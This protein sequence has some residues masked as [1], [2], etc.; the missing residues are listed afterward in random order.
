MAAPAQRGQLPVLAAHARGDVV[1]PFAYVEATPN[2]LDA[3]GAAN[4]NGGDGLIEEADNPAPAQY[5]GTFAPSIVAPV[6]AF[7]AMKEDASRLSARVSESKFRNANPMV[8]VR[9]G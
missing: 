1:A 2:T 9:I 7:L 3:V 5:D 8:I 4:F 6:A